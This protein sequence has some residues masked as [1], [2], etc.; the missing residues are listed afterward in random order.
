MIILKLLG[1]YLNLIMSLRK[2]FKDLYKIVL[3]YIF[4]DFALVAWIVNSQ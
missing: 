3:E 4:I 2:K 1:L